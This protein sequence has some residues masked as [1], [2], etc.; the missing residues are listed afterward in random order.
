[1]QE[2]GGGLGHK[3]EET[4]PTESNGASPIFPEGGLDKGKTVSFL[5][6]PFFHIIKLSRAVDFKNPDTRICLQI[7]THRETVLPEARR[8]QVKF[9]NL[10]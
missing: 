10:R 6:Y 2:R 1:M 7:N 9:N 5:L 3:E 4:K 8:T